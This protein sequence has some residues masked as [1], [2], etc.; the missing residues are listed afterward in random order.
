MITFIYR[1]ENTDFHAWSNTDS[2]LIPKCHPSPSFQP[3]IQQEPD[4]QMRIERGKPQIVP[5]SVGDRG[6]QSFPSYQ[7]GGEECV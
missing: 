7:E 4:L 6:Q 3:E 5:C 2:V 1:R